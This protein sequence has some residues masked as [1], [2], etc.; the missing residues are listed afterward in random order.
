MSWSPVLVPELVPVMSDVNATVPVAVGKVRVPV[1]DIVEM[2]GA[3]MV[4]LVRV[5]EALFLV[6]SE[7]LSTFPK[8]TIAF[9][10]PVTVPVKVGEARGASIDIL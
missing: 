7:V 5:T 9:V 10:I 6:A 2:T 8:P 1:L 4:L 3:V